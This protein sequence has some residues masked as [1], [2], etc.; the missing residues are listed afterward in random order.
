MRV[1]TKLT[2]GFGIL[3]VLLV[4]LLLYHVSVLRELA[5]S[6]RELSSLS[7]R[8]SQVSTRQLQYVDQLDENL[9]KFRATGDPGYARKFGGVMDQFEENLASIQALPLTGREQRETQRLGDLWGE[10]RPLG[11]AFT[12]RGPSRVVGIAESDSLDVLRAGL[13]DVRWQTRQ[14]AAVSQS[15]MIDRVRR[16]ADAARE[17][18]RLSWMAIAGAFL[19]SIVVPFF[20]VRSISRS[21]RRLEEGTRAVADGDLSYRL[22]SNRNDEFARLTRDFNVMT[23]RLEELDRAKRDFLSQISHD[24]KSPL[25]SMQETHRV[26]LE[27]LPGE[28][29]AKQRRFLELSLRNGDRLGSMISDLLDLSRMQAGVLEYDMKPLDAGALVRRVI[30]EHGPVTAARGIECRAHLPAISLFVEGDEGRL[31]QLLGNLLDNSARYSPEGGRVEVS[32]SVVDARDGRPVE[33][34]AGSG[35]DAAGERS[36]ADDGEGSAGDVVSIAIADRGPGVPDEEKEK[37]FDRFYRSGNGKASGAGAG[38]GLA[39]CREIASAHGG[40]VRVEDR[41]GGGSVFRVL[42]P[43]IAVE[44]PRAVEPVEAHA[45]A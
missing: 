10:I 38:L 33:P 22:T 8:V 17:S 39:I 31:T 12:D 30:E 27:E 11:Q 44:V 40:T 26:L 42:L 21:L 35:D 43:R 15:T 7:S 14:V 28:L 41:P 4:G 1:A 32:V 16:S 36:P 19:V 34:G 37:V 13:E 9:L 20:V 3:V 25:A 24:L 23:R 18:E 5:T 6:T 45:S 29:N 2:A